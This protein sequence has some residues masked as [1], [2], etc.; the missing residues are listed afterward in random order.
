[1]SI[2]ALPPHPVVLPVV[3]VDLGVLIRSRRNASR[4]RMTQA[5][6][7][8]MIGYSAAWGPGRRPPR[9]TPAQARADGAMRLSTA[10]LDAMVAEA[11]VDAYDEHEQLAAF[12][13]VIEARLALP[14]ATVVL[15]IPVTVTAIQD[16]PGSGI[17]A[18]CR[19]S[20]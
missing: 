20:S 4:P 19:C 18:R 5:Q 15:G 9:R 8:A 10:A 11:I 13:A 1:M 14:F 7:G 6:L 12:Q 2:H 16:R 3:A 17:A